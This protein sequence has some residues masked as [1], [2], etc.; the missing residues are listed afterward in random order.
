M[1]FCLPLYSIVNELRLYAI[2]EKQYPRGTVLVLVESLS[3]H[4]QPVGGFIPS[5][6]LFPL[7]NVQL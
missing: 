4:W 2:K 6:Q 3:H 5:L 1:V 7:D